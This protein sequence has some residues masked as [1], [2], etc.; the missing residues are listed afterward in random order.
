[1]AGSRKHRP[2]ALPV[3]RHQTPTNLKHEGPRSLG[4]LDSRPFLVAGGG[5]RT[6]DLR[7]YEPDEAGL[8]GPSGLDRYADLVTKRRAPSSSIQREEPEGLAPS[9]GSHGTEVPFV[10]RA[11]P[12]RVE[13]LG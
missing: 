2:R 4:G 8:P 11:N 13:P 1:M 10:E 5:I 6:R 3:K 12:D 7:G 9:Q